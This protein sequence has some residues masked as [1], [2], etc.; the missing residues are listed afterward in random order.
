MPSYSG[1]TGIESKIIN[2]KIIANSNKRE[3]LNRIKNNYNVGDRILLQKPGL[4]RKI[5]ASKD[6]PYTVLEV[7]TNGMVKIQ[8][9]IVHEHVNIRRIE[10]FFEH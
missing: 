1:Q 10:H 7:G 5:S 8:G 9:G 2:K 6:G 4:R 3:N